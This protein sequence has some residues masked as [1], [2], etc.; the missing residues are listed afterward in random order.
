[1]QADPASRRL[2]IIGVIL[3]LLLSC[4]RLDEA[5]DTERRALQMSEDQVALPIPPG[6]ES[7]VFNHSSKWGMASAEA[8]YS[9]RLR[10]TQVV[11]F[12]QKVL[13][14]RGWTQ[15]SSAKPEI[16]KI[17]F[18]KQD[19]Q[20]SIETTDRMDAPQWTYSLVFQWKLTSSPCR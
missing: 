12:Y 13:S 2:A 18:C 19:R 4:K 8:R 3:L 9:T 17:V 7:I 5:G 15:L 14:S 16:N 10:P 1:M 20:S 11:E 6:T